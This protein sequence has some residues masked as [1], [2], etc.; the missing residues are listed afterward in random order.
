MNNSKTYTIT[1]HTNTIIECE[2]FCD[3]SCSIIKIP[4]KEL[5]SIIDII[6]EKLKDHSIYFLLNKNTKQIYIGKANIRVNGESVRQRLLEHDKTKKF[7]DEAY[8][9]SHYRLEENITKIIESKLISEFK[10][11]FYSSEN[12]IDGGRQESKNK[13]TM[14]LSEYHFS[15]IKELISILVYDIFWE[16]EDRKNIISIDENVNYDY[17]SNID[18]KNNEIFKNNIYEDQFKNLND[19]NKSENYPEFYFNRSGY[20]ATMVM[21]N[22]KEYILKSGSEISENFLP[23]A[24][25]NVKK[26]REKNKH[27]IMNNRL[28][29]DIKFSS[30]SGAAEFVCGGPANGNEAWKEKSS[31]KSPEYFK[32]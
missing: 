27:L 9:Y 19:D 32:K 12:G 22:D 1:R 18:S 25:N 2:S 14:E 21:I 20:K 8:I 16:K 6:D 5:W 29:Q 28:T 7:W 3:S 17:E 13:Q 24:K 31:G 26:R 11:K 30:P 10:N 4:R 23:S 15:Q